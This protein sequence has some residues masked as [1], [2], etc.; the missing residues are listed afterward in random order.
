MISNGYSITKSNRY[1][2]WCLYL[3][4]VPAALWEI[5][6]NAHSAPQQ[7]FSLVPAAWVAGVLHLQLVGL[8]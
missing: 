4:H 3:A 7:R 5:D 8:I 6:D 1:L 2:I